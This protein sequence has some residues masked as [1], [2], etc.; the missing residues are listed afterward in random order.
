MSRTR[1]F[2]PRQFVVHAIIAENDAVDTA[3]RNVLPQETRLR[4]A[5]ELAAEMRNAG[6][7]G[8]GGSR[9]A[10]A[11]VEDFLFDKGPCRRREQDFRHQAASPGRIR[12]IFVRR[13]S[14]SVAPSL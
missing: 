1:T 13:S 7:K 5:G 12:S 6:T 8:D 4:K 11:Q 2:I 10:V 9:A 3:E 14:S